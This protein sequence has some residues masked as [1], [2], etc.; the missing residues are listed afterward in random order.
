MKK[1][2]ILLILTLVG[3]QVKA[4]SVFDQMNDWVGSQLAESTGIGAYLFL[5]MGGVLASLLPCVYPVYP[6]TVSFLR[7]KKSSLGKF[8]HPLTYYFGLAL[9]YFIF[10]LIASVTGGAFNDILRLPLAN[11]SIG[12]LLII[13]ALATIDYLHLPFFGGQVDSK[14][15]GLGGTLLMGAG[16]GLLSSAC[17]GPIVVS[18]LVAIASNVEGV[19]VGLAATAAFK[20]MLF[21]L[22]VG[23]PV[24]LLGV[25]GLALPKSGK[26]M[27]YVQWVFALLIGY[28]AYGYLIKGF[29]GLG[30]SDT[31]GFYLFIGSVLVF[32][33][34][35]N[36]QETGKSNQQKTKISLY[37]LTG[38]VGFFIIGANTL[39]AGNTGMAA[40]Q[41]ATEGASNDN[42]EQKGELTWYLNK[43]AAYQKAAETG[44]LVFVDFHGDWCTNCKAFQKNTQEDEALNSALQNAILYK[45]YDTSPEFEKYR[46]DPRFP[47]LKVG[48]PFFLITDGTGNVIYKT[49][50][51][52]KTEEMQL[53]LN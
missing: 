15:E 30:L 33:A 24:L 47:E 44:K 35:F 32:L 53:F 20:M 4:Q 21:G 42:I 19:T 11:L 8:A 7:N 34:A 17:V 38:V 46:N 2:S 37:M 10:G 43:E 36:L 29:N 26:W 22:G 31:V 50:D 6:L 5:F 13:L 1:I 16:A 18:I 51:Y 41:M 48:L 45:V 3:S 52:T 28:F 9:I 25:F 27:L 40:S 14:Q 23:V 39:P 12:L 49:N